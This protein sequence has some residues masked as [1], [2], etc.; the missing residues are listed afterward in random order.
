M[1]NAT[2]ARFKQAEA[3]KTPSGSS[4]SGGNSSSG[5]SNNNNGA[6]PLAKTAS[7]PAAGTPEAYPKLMSMFGMRSASST[8]DQSPPKRE[9]QSPR[10]P[11]MSTEEMARLESMARPDLI[12]TVAK[13]KQLTTRYQRKLN[14]LVAAYK[15]A[16]L[17]NKK[18]EAALEKQQDKAAAR[19][20]EL[21]EGH[22]KDLATK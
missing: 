18:L 4:S 21:I 17:G 19:T 15:D 8:P 14:D 9:G 11:N 12:A 2:F 7:S 1:F 22:K 16:S 3:S 5:G 6:S 10:P 20:R 13:Q